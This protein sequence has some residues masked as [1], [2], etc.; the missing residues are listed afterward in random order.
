[1]RGRPTRKTGSPDRALVRAEESAIVADVSVDIRNVVKAH[2]AIPAVDHLSLEVRK[3]EFF[4][5][6]G[7]SGSGKTTTL[8]LLAGFEHPDQGDI[9]I[10]GRSM[11]L[12]PPNHRP[13][14][15]VFQNYAL[16]P[17]LTVF[18]NISF[19]LEMRRVP[20][21]ELRSLVEAALDMVR[22]TSKQDRLPAQLSGGEQQRVALARALVNRPS[23]LLLDEPL[24]ALDQQLRQDMQV[25]LKAI[26]EQVG[27]TFI[28][29]T[30]HQEEALTMSDRVAIMNHGRLLQVGSPQEIYETP[31]SSFVANFI[32]VSNTLAGH[33]RSLNGSCCDVTVPGLPKA[34]AIVARPP[35]GAGVGSPVTL[36]LRP[37]RLHLSRE[38]SLAGFDNTI[39]A[40]ISKA[41]YNG[42]EMHYLLSLAD[43]ISWKARVP[44]AGGS[45]KRFLPGEAVFV[46]WTVGEGVVLTE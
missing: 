32:G 7:P 44:N 13:V 2:G 31:V 36:V 8:R 45:R 42:S 25:E 16:F 20:R 39:E 10:E 41:I 26:Q 1:M 6:L 24:G 11:R 12:V 46:R 43:G 17:H 19:G 27:I 30:H 37:E 18:G 34:Q 5:I 28:C 9:L 35:A 21:A 23:V 15:L 33:I 38:V 4:S 14:N 3:G 29:V 40:R 22:L